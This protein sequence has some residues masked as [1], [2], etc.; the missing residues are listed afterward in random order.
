M[1]KTL[2]IALLGLILS[3]GA[4]QADPGAPPPSGDV[5]PVNATE[6]LT[7]SPE[8]GLESYELAQS[9]CK[10]CRKG[11]ACGDSCISKSKTCRKGPGCACDAE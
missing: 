9:C 2:L 1:K 7:G 3:I 4:S 5:G 8:A 6:L 10:L 11:K